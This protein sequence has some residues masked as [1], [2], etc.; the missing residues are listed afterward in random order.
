MFQMVK[1]KD[2]D[3]FLAAWGRGAGEEDLFQIWHSSQ[4]EGGSN[5]VGYK[6]HRL[7]RLIEEARQEFDAE[8]RALLNKQAH[9][10]L[11]E[12]QPVLFMFCRPDL[13]A[14][15]NR[16]EN[17]IEYPGG[18]ELQKWTVRLD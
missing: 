2:F 8:K 14:R 13:M 7:D 17:V 15:D 5:H 6:N 9:R 4:A 3:A 16:F 10:I 18:F 12:D 1:E 11:Y